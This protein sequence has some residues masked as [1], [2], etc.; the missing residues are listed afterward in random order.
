VAA[1]LAVF[2]K[3][4][5]EVVRDR[6]TLIAAILLP[7]LLMPVVVLVMPLLARRQQAFLAERP[8]R[9]AVERGDA[10]GLAARGFDDRVFSLVSTPNPR[11][12]LLTGSV[13]AVLVDEGQEGRGPRIVAVLFDDTRPASQAAV[14][15]V[16]R[17][18]ASLI[19]QD[20]EAAARGRGLDPMGLIRLV[21]QPRNVATPRRMGGA[22]L[23]TAL[24][25][26]LAI[27]LLLG[28]QHAALDVGVGERERGSLEALLVTPPSRWAIAGGKF[29]S[30]LAPA[31][32]ALVVM[33]A[34]GVAAA[35][36]GAAW[37]ASQPAEVGIGP[38]SLG[39]LL[40][41]GLALAGLLSATQLGVS[42]GARTLREAQ[43][44]LTGLYLLVAVPLMLVPFLDD[45][46]GQRWIWAVPVL[47]ATLA[48]R[49]I[50]AE[51]ASPFALLGTAASLSLLTAAAIAWSVRTLQHAGSSK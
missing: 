15:K 51:S 13:D 25:F 46:G 8:A 30:V 45:A 22:L 24:P 47:N 6:R 1:T 37:L 33:L 49:A 48:F 19:L 40:L 7:A 21:V 4:L 5:L 38:A 2:R 14:Q 27:W 3:E 41:V 42:L 17:V 44:G 32:L 18:A 28:G 39:W 16:A 26:F 31:A 20:L 29:L 23:S 50:L 35:K 10:T 36:I 11:A 43:Q 34:A 12:A 9:I